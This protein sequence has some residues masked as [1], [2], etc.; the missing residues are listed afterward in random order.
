MRK[1][2]DILQ[3]GEHCF[4]SYKACRHKIDQHNNIHLM[5]ENNEDILIFKGDRWVWIRIKEEKK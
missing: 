4:G 2:Y 5:D 1:T 3:V